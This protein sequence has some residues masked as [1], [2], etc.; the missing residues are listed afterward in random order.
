MLNRITRKSLITLCLLILATRVQ[1]ATPKNNQHKAEIHVTANGKKITNNGTIY[2]SHHPKLPKLKAKLIGAQ[3][4][5]VTWTL[6]VTFRRPNRNITPVH[7]TQFNG[8]DLWDFSN[9]I[10]QNFIGG[11][12]SLKA[13]DST[14]TKAL[15]AFQI[16]GNNPS[17]RAVRNYIGNKPW[18]AKAIARNE[19]G[20]QNGHYYCQFN[21]IGEEGSNYITNIKHTPNRSSDRMGWGIFQITNPIPSNAE[22]WNWQKNVDK[23]KSIIQS[24]LEAAKSYFNAIKCTYPKQYEPPP[25]YTPPGYSTTLSPIDAATIQLYNGGA[26][27]KSLKNSS[28]KYSIYASCWR[29]HPN[30]PSGKRWEFV[31]NRN[32][33]VE[34]VISVYETITGDSI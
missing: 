28:G 9:T 2:I 6:K 34:R 5:N 33:Y 8:G 10:G 15:F 25:S 19:A 3:K 31:P 22:L 18:F 17:E 32:N 12:I 23:G 7:T 20:V 14:G 27:L 29:F 24:K 21:E 11:N 13:K 26:V 1:S 16:R 30:S 4:S